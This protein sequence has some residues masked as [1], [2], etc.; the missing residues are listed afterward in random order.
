MQ[1][2]KNGH[3]FWYKKH[4]FDKIPHEIELKNLVAPEDVSLA[5]VF[6]ACIMLVS[7]ESYFWKYIFKDAFSV[8]LA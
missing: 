6:V 2:D 7:F 4:R 8:L 3:I 5:F 1:R